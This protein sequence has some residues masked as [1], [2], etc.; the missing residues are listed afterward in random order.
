MEY[1]AFRAIVAVFAH[2]PLRTSAALSGWLW[3]VVAP[4]T[5][6][7][8]RALDH[9]A[10]AFPDMTLAERQRITRDMWDN[11]GRTFAEFPHIPGIIAQKR[12]ETV[13]LEAVREA[14]ASGPFVLCGLH[15]SNWELLAVAAVETGVPIVGVYQ[16]VNNRRVDEWVRQKRLPYYAGGLYRKSR[17][18][19]IKL[20]RATQRDACPAF[21]GDLR[22]TAGVSAPFFGRLAR[23]TTVPATN[24][25]IRGLPLFA[26]RVLRKSGEM[27]EVR[28]VHVEV[29]RSDDRD[30][31][32]AVGTANLQAQFEAFIR[33]APE[34]WTWAHRRGD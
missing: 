29:P 3:R 15:M 12:I 27:F 23:S 19:A 6:R 17:E 10:I 34:Q 25:R 20:M 14:L 28:L 22:D 18:A 4:F 33:E 2:L 13:G 1:G 24:A 7:Q 11:L 30:A 32:I 9:L 5:R 21:L 8:A 16:A 26:A 31:D